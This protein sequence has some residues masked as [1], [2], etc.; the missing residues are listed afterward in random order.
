MVHQIPF[1]HL[2]QDIRSYNIKINQVTNLIFP[3]IFEKYKK[4]NCLSSNPPKKKTFLTLF[5][6]NQI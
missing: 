5:K 3:D 4:K 1:Y 6:T 2:A